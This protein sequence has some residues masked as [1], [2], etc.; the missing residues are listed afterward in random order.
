MENNESFEAFG[1]SEGGGAPRSLCRRIP[2]GLRVSGRFTQY[3][4]PGTL[5]L[6]RVTSFKTR[7]P[8]IGGLFDLLCFSMLQGHCTINAPYGLL[9]ILS[10]FQIQ[11]LYLS[12]V[13]C[14]NQLLI[15]RNDHSTDENYLASRYP[16]CRPAIS[17]PSERGIPRIFLLC[18]VYS[19]VNILGCCSQR[20][21][22]VIPQLPKFFVHDARRSRVLPF[23][24]L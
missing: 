1:P 11:F 6:R 24:L 18:V 20:Q 23:L 9:I 3:L 22:V 16:V 7:H 4:A 15:L 8:Q 10:L 19:E 14:E 21:H 5:A 2:A 12:P 17:L 13:F